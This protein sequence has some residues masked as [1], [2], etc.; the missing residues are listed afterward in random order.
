VIACLTTLPNIIHSDSPSETLS[1][2]DW[3][4]VRKAA[5]ATEDD[6]I[7]IV[8]GDEQDSLAGAKEIAIR[9]G[10]AA[11]GIPSE[12][13]QALRDGTNGFERILP[14]P[15]RMY[16]DTDLPPKRITGE[17]L[18]R[19][20]LSLPTPVWERER[21]YETLGIP[22]DTCKPLAASPLAPLFERLVTIHAVDPVIAAVTLIQ[23]PK[24]LRRRRREHRVVQADHL[25]QILQAQATGALTREGIY[26]AMVHAADHHTLPPWPEQCPEGEIEAAIGAAQAELGRMTL[27]QPAKKNSILMGLAMARLR[28]R[29]P[30]AEVARRVGFGSTR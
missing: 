17:R 5:G 12:T 26:P 11:V 9:A 22:A 8:W 6:T 21:W 3:K 1:T 14:G 16:P 4:T 27:R 7:V 10:E 13:R 19:I 20:R 30:G 18:E 2:S 24:R 28:G 29:V 25:E 15:D 23:L